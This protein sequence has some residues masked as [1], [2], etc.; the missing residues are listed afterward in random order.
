[1]RSGGVVIFVV[2]PAEI[3][4]TVT[5]SSPT[6]AVVVIP[7]RYHST[8]L[9]RKALADISGRPMVE[10]VYERARAA[11]SV[12]GVIVATDDHRIYDAVS[13]FGGEARMTHGNH[14]N[15]TERLAEVASDLDCD[16]VV[17]VQADEP[18][19]DPDTIDL[20]LAAVTTTPEVMMSTV[21]CPITDA[22]ELADPNV[23]KVVV[24]RDGFALYFSRAAIPHPTAS[25]MPAPAGTYKH[26]GLYVYRRDFLLQLAALAPTPLECA[27]QLE[28]LRALEHGFRIRTVEIAH[29]PVGV[30]TPEDLD[31]VRRIV[32]AGTS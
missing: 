1:M 8:R 25:D 21:R 24:N 13:A 16:F 28:Q 3:Q 10:H 31:R 22:A 7:A 12:T 27:E 19:V 23:V 17:N 14:R 15:G 32:S 9:P 26:V 20:A 11:S 18:L 5:V 2:H 30:D 29:G 4:G 6:T